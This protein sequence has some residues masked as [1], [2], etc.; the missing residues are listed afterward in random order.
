VSDF[1]LTFQRE[2]LDSISH[3]RR[4]QELFAEKVL[5]LLG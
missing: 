2:G 5:P 3:A 1:V 4:Q